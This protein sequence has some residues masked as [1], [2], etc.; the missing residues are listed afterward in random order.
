MAV[1]NS[2]MT[3]GELKAA[4]EAIT[5]QT[6]PV[7]IEMNIDQGQPPGNVTFVVRTF[8]GGQ[9]TT[10]QIVAKKALEAIEVRRVTP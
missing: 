9:S 10:Q 7:F 6:L 5:D 4:C 8:V 2:G 1:A 3:V